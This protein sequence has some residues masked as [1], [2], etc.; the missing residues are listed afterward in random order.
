MRFLIFSLV[1][2]IQSADSQSTQGNGRA[3]PEQRDPERSYAR[4]MVISQSGIVATSQ[5]L[6]SQAGAQI[7][8]RG[9]SAVDAAIAANAVLGV[10][11]P[12]MNGIGGDLFAIYREASTGRLTGINASGWTPKGL[13]LD[14]ITKLK[15]TS[16]ARLG[17][18]S[19]NVPGCVDGWW[20]MHQRFGKLPWKDLFA[21]AIFYAEH[22]FPVTEL[23]QWDWENHPN[24]MQDENMRRVFWPGGHAPKVGEVF[25]NPELAKAYRILADGGEEAFYRGA[26]SDAILKTSKAKGGFMAADDLAE[27]SSEWVTPIS[28]SYRGWTV[29]ELPPN[30]QGIGTLMML[31]IMENFP[32][33]RML[34]MSADAYH[35]R[36]EA[37]KLSYQDQRHYV[38]DPRFSKIPVE[39][40]LSKDYAKRRAELIDPAKAACS[41]SPGEPTGGDTI[42]L[43]VVDREGN[44]AS[45]IQ[46][47]SDDW[48]A[49]IAVE[50]MG[51]PLHNRGAAFSLDPKSANV[52]GP[53]KRPYHT[54][55]PALME[56]GDEHIG[57]G[58]M[59][60]LN[61]PQAQAQFV[62]NLVDYGMNLQQAL[63]AP[64]FR[65]STLGG[66]DLTI[67]GRV[68]PSVRD[69]LARRGHVLKVLGDYA[70]YMGGGQAV[71]HNS[72]TKVNF[73]AS[74]PRKDGAAIP[75]PEAYFA[76]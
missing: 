60:G 17:I 49:G 48:G 61:Q 3:E 47:N 76:K 23:I 74:S 58:I 50:G 10:V 26:I 29:Y 25:R 21:P 62:S 6:A 59:G 30:G 45:W 51:F 46:S 28:T 73:G 72:R 22:G 16:P 75:E 64:R 4:S 55:I 19:A 37:Q 63:E 27:F 65:K 31:N 40:L 67:E 68:P 35:F 8:A 38:S 12:M 5:T 32:L 7:L 20:K 33:A 13:T 39:G 15:I 36:I 24:K 14:A 34:P 1:L 42:Y 69:E 70:G 41:G 11:E 18:H 71:M 44:I 54:I 57:F 9:G 53:R 56:R 43:S 66:C 52:I 2:M